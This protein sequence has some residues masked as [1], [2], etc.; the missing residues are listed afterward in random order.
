VAGPASSLLALVSSRLVAGAG[1]ALLASRLVTGAGA[2]LLVASGQVCPAQQLPSNKYR[3]VHT[4][5]RSE[6]YK[7][8]S[9]QVA[10]AAVPEDRVPWSVPWPD[11][12]PTTFTAPFVPGK[13]WADKELGEKGFKP[14][15]NT[16]DGDINR[17][18]HQGEY[19]VEEG[20]PLNIMGRTGLNGRGVLGKWGPNH[21]ADPIVTRWKREEGQ[22]VVH[23]DTGKQVLEFVAIQRKDTGAWAIPG[24][25][26]DPGEKV[27]VTVKREFMEEALDSTGE[28]MG[29]K[30]EAL[31]AMVDNFFNGGEEVYRGYVD[32]PRNTDNC[33]ME[34]VAFNFHDPTG[35][36]VGQLPLQAGDDAGDIQWMELSSKVVLYASHSDFVQKV[37]EKLGAHW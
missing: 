2:E 9:E 28:G 4:K 14:K 32:D 13:P 31:T 18:S 7:F 23:P 29:E 1:A 25:M 33:W 37:V 10:R 34:T 3:M 8:G 19:L 35:Q 26:V 15:W 17:A 27:S 6:E 22:V 5:C 21:A 24:G 16:L 12:S 11:Y 36:E 20:R 30:V